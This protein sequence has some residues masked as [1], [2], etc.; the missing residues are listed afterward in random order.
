MET[1]GRVFVQFVVE[2]DGSTSGV[3]VVK[4]I[5]NG[6]DEEAMRVLKMV[7]WKPG[8]QGHR[9]VRVRMVL[10]VIFQLPN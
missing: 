4:G 1:Q 6:C 8:K 2:R 7:T 3:H 9:T 10:P 5:G